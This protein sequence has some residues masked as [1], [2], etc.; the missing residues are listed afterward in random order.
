[1][2]TTDDHT[3]IERLKKH[4]I[5]ITKNRVIIFKLFLEHKDALSISYI[6][7]NFTT[8]VDR[9]TIYRALKL[10]LKKGLLLKVPNTEIETTYCFNE[11]EV[12]AEKKCNNQLAYLICTD[13]K[14]V[15]LISDFNF[16]PLIFPSHLNVKQCRIFIEGACKNCTC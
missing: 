3:I 10:F 7:K 1:M 4:S 12:F 11:K 16:H 14:S 8:I 15:T 13:C 2:Y 6:N 5:G 9:V